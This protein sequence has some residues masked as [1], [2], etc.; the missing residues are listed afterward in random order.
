VHII[1]PLDLQFNLKCGCIDKKEN[2]ALTD[3]VKINYV[4][5]S[6]YRIVNNNEGTGDGIAMCLEGGWVLYC[7]CR[8]AVRRRDRGLFNVILI[9][10]MSEEKEEN[11]L[12]L[13]SVSWQK[14]E[15]CFSLCWAVCCDVRLDARTM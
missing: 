4:C 2:R 1:W 9:E 3:S 6:D 12:L 8:D 5:S 13:Y 14:F 10:N 11:S 15:V 7:T